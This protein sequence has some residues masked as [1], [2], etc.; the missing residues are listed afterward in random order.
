MS[1]RRTA[2]RLLA[3]GLV[4]LLAAC[5]TPQRT[6]APDVQAWT[7]RLALTVHGTPPQAFSAG[8]EL[9]GEPEA[10]ELTLYTPLGGVLGVMA[11]APG[12]AT[13]RT[14]DGERQ[15]ASLDALSAEVT[16]AEIPVAALFDWLA[17]KPTPVPGWQADLAQVAAGRLRAQRSQPAPQA[18]LRIAFER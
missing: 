11:W 9:K 17:G 4:L 12:S 10:G 5:A 14:S 7:G 18:D 6:A 13:L 3:L 16:G 15:F 2:A 8:F 1:P